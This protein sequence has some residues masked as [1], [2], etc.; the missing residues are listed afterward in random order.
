[1]ML[2]AKKIQRTI[3][4]R[5]VCQGGPE[6]KA[7]RRVPA[8]VISDGTRQKMQNGLTALL[9]RIAARSIKR[10]CFSLVTISTEILQ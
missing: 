2:Q 9:H 4:R 10:L 5:S 6:L 1:M 3:H 7:F 8:Q